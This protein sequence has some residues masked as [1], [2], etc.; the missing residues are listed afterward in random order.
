MPRDD[1]QEAVKQW[2]VN[3]FGEASLA[4][5]ERVARLLE[6]V[7]ELAQAEQFPPDQIARLVDHVYSKPPGSRE[8]EIGGIG[9]TLLA[10]EAEEREV[11]RVMSKTLEHFRA[12]QNAK[13][14]AGVALAV[15]C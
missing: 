6:E 10:Y 7:I 8:Q 9:V 15:P 11:L 3:A 12:R 4:V 5:H 14:A 2:A 1:R 13:A